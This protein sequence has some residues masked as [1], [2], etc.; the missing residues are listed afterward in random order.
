MDTFAGLFETTIRDVYFA[1][2]A[3]LKAPPK[4]A[5][6]S[7][8]FKLAS[9]FKTH[10]KETEGPVEC[11]ERIFKILSK[12]ALGKE[13]PAIEGLIEEADEMIKEVKYDSVRDAGMMWSSSST[14]RS[15]RRRRRTRS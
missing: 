2:K 4:M 8:S 9:A 12:S 11:L 3:I 6:E 10:I 5:K 13:C 1:E 7:S 14:P 15:R